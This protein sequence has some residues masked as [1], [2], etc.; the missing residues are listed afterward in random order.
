MPFI[1]FVDVL[2]IHPQYH[3]RAGSGTIPPIGLAYIAAALEADGFS[4]AILD[5]A[6]DCSSQSPA[7]LTQFQDYLN[8]TLPQF[9]P[10]YAIGIGPTTTPALKSTYVLAQTL[11]KIYP[12]LPLIYGGPFASMPNQAPIFFRLLR[13]TALIRGE[14]EEAFPTLVKALQ[15]GKRNVAIPGVA[16]NEHDQPAAALVAD[17]NHIPFPARH[18]LD[19]DRYRPSLR[20]NIFSGSMTPIYWS[21]GCPYQCSFCVSPMLRGNRITRRHS[22]NLFAEMRQCITQF[23][24]HG[25][26]FYDDCLF[27][28]SPQLNQQVQTFAQELIAEV[29]EI[30]WEMELRC[31]AVAA[32]TPE[33]LQLL[34]EAGCRQINMGIEKSS[35]HQLQTF[36]KQLAITD[37]ITACSNVKQTTPS[38]RLAGTFI[39]G[40]PGETEETIA[41]TLDFAISLDIDFA[42]FYPLV[43]YP[44]TP[45]FAQMYAGQDPTAWANAMM[46][47]DSNYWGEILYTTDEL[48]GWRL[49][50]VVHH[51]YDVFY[52]RAE[53]LT[54]FA[55]TT[56]PKTQQTGQTVL[57]QWRSDRFQL[58]CDR[59]R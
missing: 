55:M 40:G 22:A 51:A 56:H 57:E 11:E 39:L 54:N 48:P 31:D 50:E 8:Q 32:L 33:S 29:G 13:A 46:S 34:Y 7:G 38:I 4:V 47:D 37:V 20:R 12:N 52:S 43:V 26:I 53:W 24:I 2:L 30:I 23:G 15:Q 14:G 44:G 28:K 16:W 5:C 6:L 18:L 9:L 45:F 58:T 27:V 41:A 25:F 21:R 10:R 59:E 1:S 35:N 42:H 49:L 36:N 17:I 3:R 19:N